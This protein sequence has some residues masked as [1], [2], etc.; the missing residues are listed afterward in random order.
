LAHP[1]TDF[2]FLKPRQLLDLASGVIAMT[3]GF[4]AW[5]TLLQRFNVS[6]LYPFEGLD[7][8]ILAFGAWLFLRENMTRDLLIGVILICFGT[9]LDSLGAKA[10]S[11]SAAIFMD[12]SDG[13]TR[14]V[15]RIRAHQDKRRICLVTARTE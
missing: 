15:H 13:V 9:I 3:L 7:R 12:R 4:V 1:D 11:P 10:S 6:Y 5:L 8:V 14:V 2:Q